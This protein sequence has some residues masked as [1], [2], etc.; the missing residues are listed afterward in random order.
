MAQK[1]LTGTE[2]IEQEPPQNVKHEPAA[3]F[4]APAQHVEELHS[5]PHINLS[6]R[7]WVVVFVACFAIMAQ[8]FVVVAAGSVIAFII[9]DLGDA[10]LAGWIIGKSWPSPLRLLDVTNK[11]REP[12]CDAKRS[13]ANVWSVERCAGPQVDGNN[14]SHYRFRGRRCISSGIVYDCADRRRCA[15]RGDAAHNCNR[16][17]YPKRSTA[18]QV[19][20]TGEWLGIS[21]RRCRRTVSS[22]HAVLTVN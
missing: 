21:R 13:V 5:S 22:L 12:T 17:S 10:E 15:H 18:S 19:S 2:A 11:Q 20:S 4:E 7:T 16:S 3:D 1:E 9:R 8:V 6:W 14:S